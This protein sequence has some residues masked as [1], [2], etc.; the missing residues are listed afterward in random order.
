LQQVGG[1]GPLNVDGEAGEGVE[2]LT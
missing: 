1:T 2:D